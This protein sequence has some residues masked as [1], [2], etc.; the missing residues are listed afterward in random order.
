MNKL[1]NDNFKITTILSNGLQNDYLTLSLI[2]Q[3][4]EK[5]ILLWQ[6][7]N[8]YFPCKR[9]QLSFGVDLLELLKQHIEEFNVLIISKL[10][11]STSGQEIINFIQNIATMEEMQN[12]QVIIICSANS[13]K[14]NLKLTDFK[15]LNNVI[16]TCSDNIYSLTKVESEHI[17]KLEN[18]T[19]NQISNLSE[20][21]T[22]HRM[23]LKKV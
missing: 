5:D 1:I 11:D 3:F 17:Y 8:L 15:N 21:I 2:E 14:S 16:S 10:Q 9:L 22:R 19:S 20:S 6:D 18:L 23:I 4:K 12:K 13:G 7:K